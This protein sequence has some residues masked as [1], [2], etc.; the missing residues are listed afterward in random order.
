MNARMAPR[1]L[2]WASLGCLGY[3]L[4]ATPALGQASEHAALQ[5]QLLQ[6]AQRWSD[7]GRSDVAQQMLAKL[8]AVEPDAPEALAFSADLALH[9]NRLQEAAAI[10]QRMQARLPGHPATRTLEQVYKVYTTEREKLARMRLMARAGRRKEAADLARELFPAGA[11]RFGALGREIA[12]LTGGRRLG[13]SPATAVAR[14]PVRARAPAVAERAAPAT[15]ATAPTAVAAAGNAAT[16][17]RVA[18]ADSA[19]SIASSAPPAPATPTEMAAS[20]PAAAPAEPA[21]PTATQRAQELRRL[22]QAEHAAQRLGPALRLFEEAVQADP[23]DPWLRLELARLYVQLQLPQTARSVQDEGLQRHPQDADSRFAHA[24]LLS[25]LEDDTGALEDLQQVPPA[26]RSPGM[27]DMLQRL[28]VQ[29]V[30]AQAAT[31]PPARAAEQLQAQVRLTP[32]NPDVRLALANALQAQG[33]WGAAQQEAD[34]LQTHLPADALYPRLALLRL[35]QRMGQFAQARALSA[36][37]QQRYP[38]N[39][40]VLLHAARLERSSG[41]YG[42]A[43]GLFRQAE[44]A[45]RSAQAP[46]AAPDVQTLDKIGQDIAA[47]EARRQASVEMAQQ[48]LDK[49]ST[50]GLSSLRGW[51]RP[52]VAWLPWG[53]SGRA[54]VHAD[55]VQLDAGSYSTADPFAQRGSEPLARGLPQK[56]EG[57]HVGVGYQGDDWRWDLGETGIGFA[58]RNWVGGLRYGASSASFDYSLELAR[59]PVTGTLLSYAG[60]V[61]PQTGMPWGGVVATGVG[62]RLARDFGPY[63]SSFS[64]SVARLSGLNVADNT[65]VQW[66]LAADRDV[67]ADAVQSLNL[68]LALSGLAY[69]KD[70]SGFSWG[71]GGYYSPN[72]NVSLSLPMQWGGR[73]E[74]FTWLLKTS[75]TAS[76]STSDASDYYPTDSA[77]QQAS[78]LRYG[79]SSGSS[80]GWSASAAVEYQ[81]S[82]KLAVGGVLAR[83]V[84]DFYTPSTL[85][86]YAR[87]FLDP[88]HERL[89]AR[90]RPVQAYSQ[91]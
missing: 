56:A 21:P 30:L 9:D 53:Y 58:V 35:Q 87:Y 76:S 47:I 15:R 51:E 10:L 40:D 36:D 32:D 45:E 29:Q 88:V 63:S 18:A 86:V 85:L 73:I 60:A 42:Q 91:F 68:G 82:H 19:P 59:R 57:M 78:G 22:A 16:A 8:L 7:K 80:T 44:R 52:V 25:S 75:V 49:S 67:Y 81:L 66:R 5:A 62:A 37:L 6:S 90:P 27:Q 2:L 54:F 4:A 71:H 48:T 33:A 43:L 28:Q 74:A 84:S 55:T 12:Q 41:A 13:D 69:D 61:D 24:L 79:A 38:Q 50:E 70:L 39:V 64:A 14:A 23:D 77:M 46:G 1:P 17:A 20:E 72:H 31:L 11:P 3:L 34:W 83:E 26:A 65:R 89:A